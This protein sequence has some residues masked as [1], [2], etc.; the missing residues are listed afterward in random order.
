MI[1]DTHSFDKQPGC[2]LETGCP[3]LLALP[4]G[5]IAVVLALVNRWYR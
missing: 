5:G 3:A 2:A 1:S 4:A